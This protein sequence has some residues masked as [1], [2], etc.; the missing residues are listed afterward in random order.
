[1]QANTS[2][3][4]ELIEYNRANNWPD[5][6]AQRQLFCMRYMDSYN[7]YDAAEAARTNPEHAAM[8]LREPMVMAFIK[9]LQ[10]H[11]DHRSVISKDFVSLQWLKMLPK[12][13]GE[14]NVPMV[15]AKTGMEYSAAKFHPSEA[16]ALLKE[17]GKSAGFYDNDKNGGDETAPA[18][19]ISFSVNEAV[20]DVNITRGTK[21]ES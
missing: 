5:L 2:D 14:E 1:M 20:S 8:F 16:V 3:L 7:I 12:L 21:D 17:L 13:M 19:S 4:Q 11:L 15:D 18:L 9:D 10:V 6:C